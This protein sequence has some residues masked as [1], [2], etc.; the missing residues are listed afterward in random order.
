MAALEKWWRKRRVSVNAHQSHSACTTQAKPLSDAASVSERTWARGIFLPGCRAWLCSLSDHSEQPRARRASGISL[1]SKSPVSIN[2]RYTPR[3][4]PTLWIHFRLRTS[5]T[6]RSTTYLLSLL[7]PI[8]AR[9]IS[10]SQRGGGRI[11]HRSELLPNGYR[12]IGR[13]CICRFPK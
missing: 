12:D 5:I 4:A 8:T 3:P 1:P 13:N 11:L 6:C 10:I 7:R 2:P 9:G